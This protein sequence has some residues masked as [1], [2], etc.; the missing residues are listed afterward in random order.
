MTTFLNLAQI[1][2]CQSFDNEAKELFLSDPHLIGRRE[3][4]IQFCGGIIHYL[5]VNF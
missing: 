4:S 1:P 2:I 3:I 5:T